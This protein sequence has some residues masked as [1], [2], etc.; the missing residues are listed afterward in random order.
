MR[1]LWLAPPVLDELALS[2][3]GSSNGGLSPATLPPTRN[4]TLSVIY[5]I[6]SLAW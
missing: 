4:N 1:T 3:D 5:E 2:S 6:D